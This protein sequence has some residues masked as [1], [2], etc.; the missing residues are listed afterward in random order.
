M[1]TLTI[2][3]FK[4]T[5]VIGVCVEVDMDKFAAPLSQERTVSGRIYELTLA[6]ISR[7]YS[8]QPTSF[9]APSLCLDS[10]NL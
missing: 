10:D 9:T 3:L 7:I 8:S 4:I 2:L 6:F 5:E 1:F